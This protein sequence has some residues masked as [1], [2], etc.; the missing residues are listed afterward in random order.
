MLVK[1]LEGDEKM[2]G[3]LNNLTLMLA[4]VTLVLLGIVAVRIW[5]R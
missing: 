5:D 4:S 2:D 1:C 3:A